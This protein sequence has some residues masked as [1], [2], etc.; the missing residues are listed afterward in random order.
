MPVDGYLTPQR[1]V[2]DV[3]ADDPD[4]DLCP[5]WTERLDLTV[6]ALADLERR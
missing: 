4:D 1:G 6:A 5:R 2:V 3:E